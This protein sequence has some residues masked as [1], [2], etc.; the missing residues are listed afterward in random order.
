VLVENFSPG[1]LD[2]LGLD[3]ATLSAK[4]PELIM[5]SGSVYGQTGPLAQSWGVDGTGAALSGRL[6]LT[7]WPD[8]PPITPGS[9]PYGDVTVPQVLVT[10]ALA[11]LVKRRQTGLGCHIDASMVEVCVQQMAAALALEQLGQP[12]QRSGNRAPELLLQGVYPTRGEQRFIAISVFDARDW[13]ALCE[14]LGGDWPTADSL[15]HADTAT[16]DVLDERIAA[17]T[18]KHDDFALMR[19]LQARGVAAGVVQDARDLLERDPQLRARGMM[20]D[21]A[22]PVLGIFAHPLTP[23]HLSRSQPTLRTAPLLG[24]HTRTTC[25][26]LLGMSEHQYAS[27]SAAGLFE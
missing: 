6:G 16:L 7:G 4:R 8:R 12:L 24:E 17:V 19:Q 9:V 15:Q 23:Y 22:H 20:R 13:R 1:T 21:R 18:A 10:A 5:V 11:A 3:Y 27:L 26:D 14:E 25:R 2:K